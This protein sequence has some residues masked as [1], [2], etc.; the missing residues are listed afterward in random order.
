MTI[1]IGPLT[2]PDTFKVKRMGGSIRGRPAQI[3]LPYYQDVAYHTGNDLPTFVY[4]GFMQTYNSKV[5]YAWLTSLKELFRNPEMRYPMYI[6]ADKKFYFLCNRFSFEKIGGW[7]DFFVFTLD[8]TWVGT[9]P[10]VREAY[11]GTNPTEV[12]NDWS[13]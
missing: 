6:N 12:T 11:I 5:A 3:E 9:E 1:I 7:K 13:L 10:H 4:E 8:C 2:L